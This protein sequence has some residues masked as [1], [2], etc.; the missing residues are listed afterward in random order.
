MRVFK[1][2]G[3]VVLFNTLPLW[4]QNGSSVVVEIANEPHH[5]LELQNEE[6]RVFRLKLGPHEATLPHRHKCFY[7]YLSLTSAT[8]GNEVLGH[9][10]VLTQLD[11]G[12]LH[13]SKGGFS[14]AE[15]NELS[16]TAELVVVEALKPTG[17]GFSTPMGKFRYHN[18]ALGPLFET[19][20]VRG[21]ATTIAS[22]GRT[23][24]HAEDYDRLLIAITDLKLRE[25]VAG[26]AP[27][28]LDMKAGEIRWAPHG[29][30]HAVTNVEKGPVTFITLEF[31]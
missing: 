22:G 8:I 9:R 17:P 24:Q 16:E 23:E 11:A 14:V 18:A 10:P 5:H 21:Y 3:I 27:S 26:Q 7:A 30:T 12:E 15:R 20:T 13:T 28:E 31:D 19:A 6:V 4:T 25:E 2:L 29:M 1:I